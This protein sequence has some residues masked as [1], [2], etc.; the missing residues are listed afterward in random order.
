MLFRSSTST[1]SS[2]APPNVSS[3]QFSQGCFLSLSLSHSLSFLL[4][5]SF[6]LCLSLSPS[7]P[8][9]SLGD[10]TQRFLFPVGVMS[11]LRKQSALI[12]Q[13]SSRR[14]IKIQHVPTKD[15]CVPAL[16][17]CL[18]RPRAPS[19]S[20]RLLLPFAKKQTKDLGSLI[21]GDTCVQRNRC[22]TSLFLVNLSN[23]G[24]SCCKSVQQ[25]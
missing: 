19:C 7:P 8:S 2:Q 10:H 24:A 4:T 5:L 16:A 23:A 18:H 25:V 1:C 22:L 3:V 17:P 20:S 13:R 11:L 9:L 12:C 15:V 6:P 21:G 14:F